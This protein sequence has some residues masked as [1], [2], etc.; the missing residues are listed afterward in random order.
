MENKS[1]ERWEETFREQRLGLCLRS[2]RVMMSTFMWLFCLLITHSMYAVSWVEK[3][4]HINLVALQR[5]SEGG[6]RRFDYNELKC[7]VSTTS[8]LMGVSSHL[9]FCLLFLCLYPISLP[10]SVTLTQLRRGRGKEEVRKQTESRNREVEIKWKRKKSVSAQ[11]N[12]QEQEYT[13]KCETEKDRQRWRIW[14]RKPKLRRIYAE[15]SVTL[16]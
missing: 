2:A 9:W 11:I 13:V 10:I 6:W 14:E 7:K 5:L 1:T 12:R 3:L 8:R 15:I 4:S 16:E